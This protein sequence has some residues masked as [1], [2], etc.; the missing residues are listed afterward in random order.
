M[1]PLEVFLHVPRVAY[2]SMEIA[3]E[4][5]IPTY[6]GGLGVLA[7][8]TVRAAADLELPLVAVSL[9]FRGGHFRQ[10]IDAAGQQVEE[11]SPW[12]P[13]GHATRLA[14]KV[15]ITL[16]NREVWIGGWLYTLRG[17]MGGSQP[18]LLLD[19]DLDE[20][21]PDDRL[22]THELYGDAGPYRLKQEAVLGIGGVRLLQAL[23]FRVRQYHMNE[24]HSALLALELLHR[25]AHRPE[26]LRPGESPYD[27][28]QVRGLC[29][30]T[31]HTP[32]EAGHDRFDY[33]LVQRVLD[34]FIPLAVLKQLGGEDCLNMTRLALNLSEYVNGVAQRHAE[35]SRRMFPGYRVHAVTNGVHPHTWTAPSLR[36]LYDRYLPGWCHEPELLVRAD[37]CIPPAALLEA[38]AT[39]KAALIARVAERTDVTLHPKVPI[40]GFARRMTAYK[41]PDLLFTDLDRLRAIA[42]ERSFQVVL[43]G[44]AHPHDAGGK[45]IIE[46]LHRHVRDLAGAVPV[47]Y[48]PDY[49]LDTALLLVS[50]S[51][52]WMNTP[53]PP[54]EASGTSGMKAAFNG[55]PS[56]SVLDGWWVEGCIEGVTGWAVGAATEAG[57]QADAQALYDKLERVVLPLYYGYDAVSDGWVRVMQGAIAKNA[58]FFNSHRMMRRY[59]TEAYLL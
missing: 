52:V 3:L 53:L 23:G 49:D 48:L 7:G 30:F 39:A 17:H 9:V 20:N 4:S 55:V 18:V 51:D 45:Q 57:H 5:A 36:A 46:L 50:G 40:L 31:T 59:A 42:G 35:V 38:H 29:C 54:L 2:F 8:D 32:V 13:E 6:A 26:E 24:G 43:A 34:D 25:H 33:D 58:S 14:A 47:V 11:P 37:C 22:I 1:S 12:Q 15:A 56:L 21:H 16:E 27:V 44:K 10:G 41:R 28:P 19:T